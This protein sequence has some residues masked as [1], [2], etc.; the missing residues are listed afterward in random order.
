MPDRSNQQKN[1]LEERPVDTKLDSLKKQL[2]SD[3]DE[4]RWDAVITLE[5]IS[6]PKAT[7][8]LIL[9][10]KDD[11]FLSIRYQAAVALGIR[12]DRRA[13]GPLIAAL[14]DPDPHIRE[15][16]AEALG[17]IGD[18]NAVEPLLAAYKD[19]YPDVRRSVILALTEIGIPAEEQLDRARFS[20]DPFIRQ[21]AEEAI[22]EIRS[23]K[24][25]R[26]GSRKLPE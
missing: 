25:M 22:R 11:R 2:R 3:Y 5:G 24:Q 13:I 18:S 14:K 15:K 12:G 26:E 6:G 21:A 7:D 1:P 4:V 19:E 16:A 10:L 9:A 8:L 17:R 23:R 20:T